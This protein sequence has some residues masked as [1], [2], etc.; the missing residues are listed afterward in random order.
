MFKFLHQHYHKQYHG[1]YQHAKKLFAFDLALLFV[2][3]AMLASSLFF[4]FWKPGLAGQIDLSISLGNARIKSGEEIRL[5]VGY[6]NRSKYTLQSV[7][8]GLRLP[9]G[10]V[11]TRD[12]TATSIFSDDSIFSSITTIAAGASGQTEVYGSFWSE[13]NKDARF[14]ANLSYQP[15]NRS[16]R[17]QKLALL[18]ANISDSV[19]VGELFMATSTLPNF[20]LNF[21]YTLKNSGTQTIRHVSVASNWPGAIVDEDATANF[22]LS[23]NESKIITGAIATPKNPEITL[24][25]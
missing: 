1:I 20:P 12:K 15:G 17:E 21:T 22:S 13:P 9:E 4:F 25:A 11:I 24:L 6:V 3:L 5:T 23:P 8:L 18:T 7:S 14:V 19:L 16:N 10:F 2:A